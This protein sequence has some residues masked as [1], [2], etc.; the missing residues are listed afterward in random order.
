MEI[1][2][3]VAATLGIIYLVLRVIPAPLEA[4]IPEKMIG[5]L[6]AISFLFIVMYILGFLTFLTGIR[7]FIDL[8]IF[9]LLIFAALILVRPLASFWKKR[10]ARPSSREY[11]ICRKCGA[12]NP[13][14][15]LECGKCSAPKP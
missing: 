10:F 5:Y 1:I 14:P 2:I 4:F 13:Q 7:L 9:V 15:M 6:T 12:E 11:W 3:T 8:R